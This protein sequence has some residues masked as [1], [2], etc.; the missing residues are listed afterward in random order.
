VRGANGRVVVV[1]D[2]V[3]DEVVDDAVVAGVVGVVDVVVVVSAA[4]GRGGNANTITSR[5]VKTARRTPGT[6]LG[7]WVGA[8]WLAGW[9]RRGQSL[10][11]TFV[12]A[13]SLP[14]RV[15]VR[16]QE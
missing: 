5:R 6:S 7:W 13:T 3:V 2:D 15:A 4:T 16:V 11:V 10:A 9:A 8:R 1:V 12:R 14:A